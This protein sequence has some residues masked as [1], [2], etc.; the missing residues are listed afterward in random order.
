[1]AEVYVGNKKYA[2][3]QTQSINNQDINITAN[4]NYTADPGYTGFGVVR[5]QIPD[6]VVDYIVIDPTTTAQT[7]TPPSGIIGYNLIN[8]NPVTAEIDA[9]IKA[10]NIKKDVEILGIT[11]TLE[12]TTET[13]T[14]NPSTLIQTFTPTEDGYSR[15]TVNAVTHSIDANIISPNIKSGV[16]ILGVPG[17]CVESKETTRTITTNGL[18]TA[19]TGYTGYS[20]VDVNVEANQTALTIN[21]TTN[22]QTYVAPDNYSGFTPVVVNPVTSG[23]DTNIKPENIKNMVTILG[24]TGN[25]VPV[26]NETITITS[27]GL[28]IPSAG[29]T[30]FSEVTVDINTVHNQDITI[31]SDGVYTPEEG[32]TGFGTVTVNTAGTL[33]PTKT[34][35]ADANT[36]TITTISPDSEYAGM[37]QVVVDL[38]WI[39]QQ[40]QG[41]NAGDAEST[42]ELQDITVTQAGTYQHGAGYDGLGTVTV[43]LDWVDLAIAS[44]ASNFTNTTVDGILQNSISQLNTD[45]LSIRDYACYGMSL[46]TEANL[47]S[48]ES[49]GSN[50]FK[51]TQLQTITISTPTVCTLAD[52]TL[53]NT[54]QHIYVPSNLVN[55]YRNAT[56]WHTYSSLISAIS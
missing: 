19:P 3:L 18:Y 10:G 24:V 23:I 43:N 47:T 26:N 7:I 5:V 32:Y 14:V 52:T 17:T 29:H 11:G 22:Q 56:N 46:L 35:V 6:P 16:T 2:I 28:Y 8:V 1:M 51:N 36:S 40:L 31:T 12:F 30:G 45:A 54:L 15:V 20:E 21:P 41:L 55:A 48:C 13:L 50:V 4:G 27:N 9:N 49:I 33:Q 34:F 42:P 39:E 25:L 53:P 44:V 37:S 38:S